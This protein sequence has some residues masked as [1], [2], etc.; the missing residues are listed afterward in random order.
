MSLKRSFEQFNEIE[1]YENYN[2]EVQNLINIC[3]NKGFDE[4]V[5]FFIDTRGEPKFQET[6][7]SSISWF[8]LYYCFLMGKTEIKDVNKHKENV[9][10]SEVILAITSKGNLTFKELLKKH[11]DYKHFLLWLAFV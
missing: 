5:H 8:Y 9:Q 4:M 7:D 6:Y 3:I 1:D 2:Y 11:G 10:L